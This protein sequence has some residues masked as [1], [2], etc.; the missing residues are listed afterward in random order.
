MAP[1]GAAQTAG[2]LIY[3]NN[4]GS[5]LK[6]EINWERWKLH[7]KSRSRQVLLPPTASAE[8]LIVIK[9]ATDAEADVSSI[10]YV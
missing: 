9:T 6:L 10:L 3:V 7:A 8:H 4:R 1:C 2:D 5:K